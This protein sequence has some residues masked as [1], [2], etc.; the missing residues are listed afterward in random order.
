VD[1]PDDGIQDPGTGRAW[2]RRRTVWA[3]VT[4][5]VVVG[6]AS[7]LVVGLINRGV[8]NRIDKAIERGDRA[9]APD[10]TLPLLFST[11]GLPA[12][13]EDLTL[14]TLRGKVVVL[15]IWASWCIPCENEAPILQ[16]V[17]SRYKNRDVVVLGANVRDLE[18]E[19]REFHTTYGMT[20]PSVR[21][22]EGDIMGRYGSTGVPETFIID[23]QGRVA[24]ALR[25][26][27]IS[28]SNRGNLD[29]FQSALDTVIAETPGATP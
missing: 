25:G 3:V 4:G 13:G 29:S 26:E 1:A 15:N 9:E 11:P 12:A 18:D 24:A 19:A 20:F 14:S 22:G 16:S 17:W 21:D 2:D 28:G 8:D 5:L 6:I 10:F 27:L 7:L 23:R